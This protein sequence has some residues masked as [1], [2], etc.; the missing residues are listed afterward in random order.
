MK[1]IVFVTR[2]KADSW[3][4]LRSYFYS[5][6]CLFDFK[7]MWYERSLYESEIYGANLIILR[8]EFASYY[9]LWNFE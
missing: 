2:S 3:D 9:Y 6:C 1:S 7:L 4:E 5:I 8:N